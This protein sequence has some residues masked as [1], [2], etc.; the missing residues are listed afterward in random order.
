MEKYGINHLLEIAKR[1]CLIAHQPLLK[2]GQLQHFMDDYV[3]SSVLMNELK[4]AVKE[5]ESLK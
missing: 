4:Q 5:V 3:V 1:I 2:R